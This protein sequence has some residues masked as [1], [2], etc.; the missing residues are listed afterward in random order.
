MKTMRKLLAVTLLALTLGLPVYAENGQMET[1]KPSTGTMPSPTPQTSQTVLTQ[2]IGGDN[3][4]TQD[5]ETD[6]T[7][8]LLL[9]VI[10]SILALI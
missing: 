3:V 8:T 7:M 1:P 5:G 10:G 6:T 9:D 2:D 4:L